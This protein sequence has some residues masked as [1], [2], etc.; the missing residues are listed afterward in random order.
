MT[1]LAQSEAV[2][3]DPDRLGALY[4]QMGE[5]GAEDVICRAVE[6]LAIRLAQCERHF[7]QAKWPDLRKCVRSLVA[8]ADQIGMNML[9]RVAMDVTVAI[10]Q[11]DRVATAS[12]LARL[13]RIG[14]RSL[15]AIWDLQDMSV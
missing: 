14:Q 9:S 3:L 1:K 10:D 2:R 15:T 6:E 7:R 4:S 13:L 8:I 11:K 5:A 12:T